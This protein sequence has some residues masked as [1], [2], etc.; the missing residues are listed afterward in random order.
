MLDG[1]LGE[2]DLALPMLTRQ[3][4]LERRA[5]DVIEQ[6]GSIDKQAKS[7]NLEPF[8]RFPA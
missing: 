3:T 6:K 5:D 4:S 7:N 8:E 1:I 2:Q